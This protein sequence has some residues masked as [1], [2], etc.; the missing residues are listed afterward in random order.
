MFV[1]VENDKVIGMQ[2]FEPSVPDSVKVYQITEEEYKA[3]IDGN[4]VFNVK[5]K[6][7]TEPLAKELKEK[8]AQQ[9]IQEARKL[10][11]TTDW[12]VMRHIREKALNMKTSLTED[13]YLKLERERHMAAAKIK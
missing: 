11:N 9:I 1:C 10:L 5:K 8:E 3:I 12:Q 6:K 4:M 13:E 2:E 7:V